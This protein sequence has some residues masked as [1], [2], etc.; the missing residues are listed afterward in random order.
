MTAAIVLAGGQSSRFGGSKLEA[1]LDGRPLLDHAVAAATAVAEEVIVVLAP[2]SAN[3]ALRPGAR[4]VI[5]PEPFGGPLVGLAAGLAATDEN[6]AIVIGGDMPLVRP[7]LLRRLLAELGRGDPPGPPEAAVLDVAGDR[8][9]L[10]AALRV[11][12]ARAA[13]M[14]ALGRGD[15]SL[16]SLLD[17]LRTSGVPEA[18]WRAV[19]PDGGSLVDVDRPE[20]LQSIVDRL[21]AS[22][23][24]DR[25]L[26]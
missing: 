26:R 22:D 20:D 24:R 18:E 13:S 19:D 16:R 4:F 11:A 15:R 21:G 9:P 6:L 7:A 12:P 25:G 2:G 1:I 3:V 10:P 14:T 23:Q 17:R 5:D 8:R